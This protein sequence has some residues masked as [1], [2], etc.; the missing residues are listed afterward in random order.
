MPDETP[1]RRPAKSKPVVGPCRTSSLVARDRKDAFR[2]AAG[3]P[4][5]RV[6]ALRPPR[7]VVAPREPL[8]AEPQAEVEARLTTLAL[9]AAPP[10]PLPP[11][12]ESD[13][14][15]KHSAVQFSKLAYTLLTQAMA[16]WPDDATLAAVH[17]TFIDGIVD[18]DMVDGDDAVTTIRFQ[19]E[20]CVSSASTAPPCRGHGAASWSACA[21]AR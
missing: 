4:H 12:A 5:S 16:L 19:A 20:L 13:A 6:G 3:N 14:V 17:D 15:V 9:T 1:Q 18:G 2:R 21:A 7:H 11:P 10:E 8:T